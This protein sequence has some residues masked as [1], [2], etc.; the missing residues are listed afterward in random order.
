M[1]A[2]S[3]CRSSSLPD[4]CFRVTASSRGDSAVT[5]RDPKPSTSLMTLAR[6]PTWRRKWTWNVTT[7]LPIRMRRSSAFKAPT[8]TQTQTL[9]K[10]VR[11]HLSLYTGTQSSRR[12]LQTS[13]L[14]EFRRREVRAAQRRRFRTYIPLM[15]YTSTIALRTRLVRRVRW[16]TLRVL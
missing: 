14:C 13:V 8:Q 5:K 10:P 4:E 11:L 3:M 16:R 6:L 15:E 2:L 12:S 9:T 7:S 1:Q